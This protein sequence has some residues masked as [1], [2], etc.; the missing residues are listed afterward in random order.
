[1]LSDPQSLTISGTAVSLPRIPAD[2]RSGRFR[3]SDGSLTLSI[4]HSGGKRERSMVRLDRSKIGEDV[5]DPT[6][7]RNFLG[8]AWLVVDVPMN[9]VG[10]TDAEIEADVKALCSL[11]SSGTFLS[12]F[13]GKE[14]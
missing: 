6:K 11:I 1:M 9:G 2:G 5:L 10:F 12:K 13:L 4:S 14:A 3:N 8:S 7:M